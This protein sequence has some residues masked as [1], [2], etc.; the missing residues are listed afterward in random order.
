MLYHYFMVCCW[1]ALLERWVEYL[2][3]SVQ[4]GLLYTSVWT[5][6]HWTQWTGVRSPPIN[7]LQP[8]PKPVDSVPNLRLGGYYYPRNAIILPHYYTRVIIRQLFNKSWRGYFTR[9][10]VVSPRCSLSCVELCALFV[11]LRAATV[12]APHRV[13]AATVSWRDAETTNGA[14]G[15]L[16]CEIFLKHEKENEQ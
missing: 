3:Q 14:G 9:A 2:H 8:L 7:Q 5:L 12:F 4:S 11:G 10:W 15:G 6:V 13:H 16:R 1:N